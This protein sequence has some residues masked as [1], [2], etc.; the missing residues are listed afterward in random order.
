MRRARF[1][2]W[3]GRSRS[4]PCVPDARAANT[5]LP[6]PRDSN[7]VR[8]AE[9][10]GR[11]RDRRVPVAAPASG[12]PAIPGPDRPVRGRRRGHPFGSR[13]LRDTPAPGSEEVAFS[14]ASISRPFHANELLVAQSDR[15][16]VRRNYTQAN[17]PGNLPQCPRPHQS[18]PGHPAIQQESPTFS[19][20]RQCQ[21]HYQEGQQI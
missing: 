13:Q 4:F 7:A 9:R 10:T 14:T 8:C 21:S 20:G 12:V 6:T 1:R 2:R 19:L 16:L 11:D 17:P 15:T 18:Y 5:R 3:T